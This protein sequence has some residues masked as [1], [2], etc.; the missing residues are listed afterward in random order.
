MDNNYKPVAG[1]IYESKVL[2]GT[3]YIVL[4]AGVITSYVF[5]EDGDCDNMYN[6]AISED[7]L[8]DT[9]SIKK[10]QEYIFK[11]K[12]VTK[13]TFSF[14][15]E[16]QCIECDN[17]DSNHFGA[18]CMLAQHPKIINGVC[19]GYEKLNNGKE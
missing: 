3:R 12:T 14:G 9:I 15:N 5:W 6:S 11:N 16:R 17:V 13:N 10:L 8:I 4:S 2:T 1:Q 18:Y 7:K 19:D